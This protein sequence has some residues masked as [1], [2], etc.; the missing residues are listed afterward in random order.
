MP[1]TW[2]SGV[3][4]KLLRAGASAPE[5]ELVGRSPTD[6]GLARQRKTFTAAPDGFAGQIPMTWAQYVTFRVF[7]KALGGATVNWP[8]GP[9]NTTLE[10]RFIAGAQ[11]APTPH[12]AAAKWLVPVAFEVIP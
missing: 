3:P 7:R 10:V 2:P 5:G 9:E 11:G 12:Q 6:S 1:A 4:Y 8:G